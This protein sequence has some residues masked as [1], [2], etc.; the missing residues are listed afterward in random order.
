MSIAG[1]SFKKPLVAFQNTIKAHVLSRELPNVPSYSQMLIKL[2]GVV[3][4]I[5]A[6]IDAISQ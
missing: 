4:E 2:G 5:E 6:D 1:Q 3:Q